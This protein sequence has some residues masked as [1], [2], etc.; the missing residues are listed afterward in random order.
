ML[1][2]V[3]PV[4][5]PLLQSFVRRRAQQ[6]V[7][8]DVS[9]ALFWIAITGLGTVKVSAHHSARQAPPPPPLQLPTQ[10]PTWPVLLQWLQSE[11]DRLKDL[12]VIVLYGMWCPLLLYLICY[13]QVYH[14]PMPQAAAA[15]G[16]ISSWVAGLAWPG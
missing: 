1:P 4:L 8:Q 7:P 13:R 12:P 11:R 6:L 5:H 16:G 2:P 15:V 9:W 3:P 14:A 10:P